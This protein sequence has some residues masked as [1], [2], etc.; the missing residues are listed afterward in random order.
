MKINWHF[1]SKVKTKFKLGENDRLFAYVYLDTKNPPETVQLQFNNG[2][3]EHRA[4]WGADKGHGA[5]RN[6]ASNLKMGPLPELGKWI[7]LE[8]AASKVGLPSGSELNGWAFTQF[9]G[10]VY[11]DKP[12]RISTTTLNAEQK[13]SLAIWEQYRKLVKQPNRFTKNTAA[14][15]HR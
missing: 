9:G 12:G 11:W 10:T 2:N 5:G 14:E 13:K 4:Y 15:G 8:V 7:R 3:W 1:D 6:N